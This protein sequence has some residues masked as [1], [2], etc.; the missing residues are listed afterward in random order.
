MGLLSWLFPSSADRLSRARDLFARGRYDET[1]GVLR[2]VEGPEAE[3]LYEAASERLGV[4]PAP[5]PPPTPWLTRRYLHWILEVATA[6]PRLRSKFFKVLA[7]EMISAGINLDRAE[8]DLRAF[9]GALA[10]AQQSFRHA[11]DGDPRFKAVA[12][13]TRR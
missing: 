8:L 13:L 5:T 7:R 2:G 6:D 12:K 11:H 9:N 3:A 4:I 10:E 1:R